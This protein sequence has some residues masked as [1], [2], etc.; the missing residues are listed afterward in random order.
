MLRRY[1]R[2]EGTV[3]ELAN[4][5]IGTAFL[6]RIVTC[7]R[8]AD[9][10]NCGSTSAERVATGVVFWEDISAPVTWEEVVD[11]GELVFSFEE[12]MGA[13]STSASQ[14]GASGE[15]EGHCKTPLGRL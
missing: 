3:I 12:R 15:P 10:G 1:L 8:F 6:P 13:R 11:F 2:E 4:E 5:F 7:M 14:S 9:A